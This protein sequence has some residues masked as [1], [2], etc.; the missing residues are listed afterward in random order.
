M[1][2]GT[3]VGA[4]GATEGTGSIGAA[5]ASGVGAAVAKASGVPIEAPAT[6]IQNPGSAIGWRA[7]VPGKLPRY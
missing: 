1:G 7:L 4:P 2:E 3:V 6:I 5:G